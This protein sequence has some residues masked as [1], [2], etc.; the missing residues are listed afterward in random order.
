MSSPHSSVVS[1][2][3][4]AVSHAQMTANEQQTRCVI[5]C[6]LVI[7]VSKSIFSCLNYPQRCRCRCRYLRFDSTSVCGTSGN[8]V[9]H[10]DQH[11]VP[12]MTSAIWCT[13][14]YHH[15]KYRP[16]AF[17]PS[18]FQLCCCLHTTSSAHTCWIMLFGIA[19]TRTAKM[20]SVSS[21]GLWEDFQAGLNVD[22]RSV[23]WR[24]CPRHGV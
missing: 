6:Q 7:S 17:V 5:R 13:C 2:W 21:V 3:V 22:H 12:H 20:K 9:Q 16:S 14:I 10:V 24:S 19:G 11:H 15:L 1:F 18:L 23:E 4:R 8:I